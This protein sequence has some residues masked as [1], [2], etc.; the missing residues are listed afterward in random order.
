MLVGLQAL[1]SALDVALR[2]QI[3]KAQLQPAIHALGGQR[4]PAVQIG[5]GFLDHVREQ[6][7]ADGVDVAGLLSPQQVAGPPD[8][9]IVGGD[10]EA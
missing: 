4:L 3:G 7:Q 6:L 9:Q 8:F 10:L 5:D 2:Q 1:L